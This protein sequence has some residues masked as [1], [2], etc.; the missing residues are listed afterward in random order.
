MSERISLFEF[1]DVKFQIAT[2]KLGEVKGY[3]I[4]QGSRTQAIHALIAALKAVMKW[5]QIPLIASE[6]L[7]Y[8]FHLTQAPESPLKAKFDPTPAP[9]IDVSAN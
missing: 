8:A 9:P 3:S 7:L 6:Y 2:I 4:I 1:L 5:I